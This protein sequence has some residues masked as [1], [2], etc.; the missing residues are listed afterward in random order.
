[1]HAYVH[2]PHYTCAHGATAGPLSGLHGCLLDLGLFFV[3]QQAVPSTDRSTRFEYIKN[4]S[5]RPPR[6]KSA[7]QLVLGLTFAYY[8]RVASSRRSS[9]NGAPISV[10]RGLLS[11][12]YTHGTKIG[13]ERGGGSSNRGRQGSGGDTL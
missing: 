8:F 3:F 11:V 9:S 12:A 6:F 5:A 13:L 10:V 2:S 4:L 7:N 1:M